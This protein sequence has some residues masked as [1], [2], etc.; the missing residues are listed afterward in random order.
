MDIED[1][2][3]RESVKINCPWKVNLYL[4]DVIH[5]TSMCNEH[6]HPLLE[7]IQ[8]VTPKFHRL[9]SEMLEEIEFLVNIGYDI[10]SI[11]CKLQKR[12]SDTVI[13]P[14]NVYNAICLF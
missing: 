13:H 4:S 9:N 1:N 14:K 6:N 8:N 5:V 10:E 2:R 11:I 7:D 3:E 12:F